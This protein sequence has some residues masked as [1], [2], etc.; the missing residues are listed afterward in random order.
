[1]RKRIITTTVISLLATTSFIAPTAQAHHTDQKTRREYKGILPDAYYNGLAKCET[2]GKWDR[3][4][5]SYT[6]GLGIAKGT[7]YRWSGKRNLHKLTAKEQVEVADRI[8]FR[9]WLNP[10][11]KVNPFKYAVGPWGWGCLKQSKYLQ[12][13]ICRSNHPKVQRWKRGC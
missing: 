9:G 1:M 7:A 11:K 6:G 2:R 13:F 8:A 5:V 4:G 10:K 3:K 12:G